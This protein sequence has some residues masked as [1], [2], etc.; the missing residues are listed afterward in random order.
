MDFLDCVS[1]WLTVVFFVFAGV[2]FAAGVLTCDLMLVLC[3]VVCVVI[4]WV[5]WW[6][7]DMGV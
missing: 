2:V 3:G 5:V 4:G 6:L 7:D 1:A